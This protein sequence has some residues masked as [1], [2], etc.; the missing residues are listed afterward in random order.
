MHAVIRTTL[1]IT[2]VLILV[3]LLLGGLNGCISPAD[4]A[5][6]TSSP[7]PVAPTPTLC[8]MT[9]PEPLWVEPVTSPTDQLS[10]MITVYLGNGEAVTITAESGTFT[11]VDDFSVYSKPALVDVAL[12]PNTV[13]HLRVVGKVRVV[14]RGG[15][16]Y[17]GYTLSTI[18]DR[19]GGPLV[20]TQAM[21][22]TSVVHFPLAVMDR[23]AS[24]MEFR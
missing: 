24:G 5:I 12:L 13:H 1:V 21:A 16:I 10:Q 17:G 8:P 11:A 6:A 19:Y 20:I 23:Q 9:T 18:W 2:T 22:I 7:T 14:E 3:G 15:C 4:T